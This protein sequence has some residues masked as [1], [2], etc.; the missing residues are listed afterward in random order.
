MVCIVGHNGRLKDLLSFKFQLKKLI[1]YI[2]FLLSSTNHHG[3]HSPFIYAY[4]TE[5]LYAHP[6]FRSKKKEHI[7]LRSLGYFKA[8]RLMLATG[9]PALK[10]KV[11]TVY[12][13]M[14]LNGK[15]NDLLFISI[16][17]AKLLNHILASD[18][19]I[20]NNSM[21]LVDAIHQNKKNE[22]E[23]ERLKTH[24]K[25]RISIDLFYCGII[26]FRAQQARE[27]FKIR[28]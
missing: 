14:G 11:K 13:S 8:E 10:I 24:S 20:H 5:C 6:K 28:I 1:R 18:D 26:F 9:S 21:L 16:S 25:A 7:L 4:L 12:P 2:K 27:H 23:W 19:E 17:D 3:V 15:P 22:F